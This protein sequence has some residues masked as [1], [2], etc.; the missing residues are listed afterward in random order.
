MTFPVPPA[1]GQPVRAELIRQIIDCLR[2]FRPLTGPNIRTRTTPG[3]TL[4]EGTPGGAGGGAAGT[5]P[6]KVRYHAP[7]GDNGQWEIWLPTGCMSVGVDLQPLNRPA[8]ESSGH[9]G[10]KPGWYLLHLD[11][12]EG[13]AETR[14]EGEGESLVTIAERTFYVTARAKTS[15]RID[16]V[17]PLSPEGRKLLYVSA[18][19][20]LTPAESAAETDVQRAANT[21]GDEFSQV[22][23]TVTVGTRQKGEDEPKAFRKVVQAAS[24]PISVQG[25]AATG[26]DLLWY[27]AVAQD[28]SLAVTRLFCVR[29]SMSAAGTTISGPAMTEIALGATTVYA[30]ILT[31]PLTSVAGSQVEVVADP[32]GIQPSNN[33]VTWLQLFTLKSNAVS[34]DWRAQSLANAQI[35]R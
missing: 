11:E 1:K 9:E 6:W 31:N 12:E 22:V 26:F 5:P 13:S 19:K 8:S 21:W 17:D 20:R 30:K 2:M 32:Q 4:L 35:Y 18:R 29:P 34:T 27:F 3:G 7:D 25:K 16:G 14:T 28:G 23:A 15:A 10:D 24:A 33:F